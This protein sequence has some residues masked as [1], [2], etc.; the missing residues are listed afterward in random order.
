LIPNENGFSFPNFGSSASPEIFDET[1]IVAM[2]GSTECLDGVAEPC[3]LTA[4][5]AA[6]ARMV[7]ETRSSGHC[8]GLVVQAATRF[9]ERQDPPTAKLQNDADVT[10]AVMRAFATQFLPEAQRATAKWAQRSL[11]DI[12]N[13]LARSMQ[14]G[15]ESYSLGLYTESGGHAV[16]PYKVQFIGADLVEVSVYD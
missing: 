15:D 10:H 12:V 14:S 5:A 13:E 11:R 2:F 9:A 16:L 4:E 7:N 8:E 3:V 6:W 1:D